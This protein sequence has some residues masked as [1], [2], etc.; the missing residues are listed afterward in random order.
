MF[1][2]F[3]GTDLVKILIMGLCYSAARCLYIWTRQTNNSS[4]FK[5]EQREVEAVTKAWLK[6]ALMQSHSIRFYAWVEAICVLIIILIFCAL[7]DYLGAVVLCGSEIIVSYFAFRVSKSKLVLSGLDYET[8]QAVSKYLQENK[9]E[10]IDEVFK[11]PEVVK[12]I[13]SWSTLTKIIN[14]KIWEGKS[15]KPIKGSEQV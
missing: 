10:L 14:F 11:D 2:S 13:S 9:T 8:F 3:F 15:F 4:E 1:E 5:T 7:G 6:S 12:E